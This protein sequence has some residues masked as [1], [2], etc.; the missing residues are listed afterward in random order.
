M[1]SAQAE[2][3]VQTREEWAQLRSR[4]GAPYDYGPKRMPDE[5]HLGRIQ[6]RRFD[7]IENLGHQTVGHRV[8]VGEGIALFAHE[9]IYM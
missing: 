1:G 8:E 7:V 6:A 3:G 5:A 4:Q 2:E 9:R